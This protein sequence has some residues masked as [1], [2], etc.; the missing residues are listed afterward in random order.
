[1]AKKVVFV[2]D[3][4]AILAS[5]DFAVADL[6]KNGTIEFVTFIN[7]ADL[8]EKAQ[9][10]TLVYDMLFTDINMPQMNGFELSEALKQ[11]PALKQKPII[12]LTTENSSDMKQ[13]GKSIGIAGWITKPFNE[14]K[15]IG[16]IKKVL[17]I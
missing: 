5:V 10:G 3:S 12:A 8:L 17:A 13:K 16:A 15:V 7:P 4:K 2:D 11:I 6:V 14:T 9:N 1:M